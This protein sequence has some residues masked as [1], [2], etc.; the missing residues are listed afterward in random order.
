M[1]HNIIQP[2][3]TGPDVKLAQERLNQRGAT[4]ATDGIFGPLTENAVRAYQTAR[5]IPAPPAPP[6]PF[7]LNWP[8][9]VD[10]IVGN[11]TWGRLDPPLTVEGSPDHRHVR[12]L[13]DLLKKSGAPGA[14]PGPIDGIFGNHTKAAVKAFQQFVGIAQDGEVGPITWGKLHS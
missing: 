5:S 6:G 2:G 1:P 9:I 13:Q 14:N 12:L 10:G 4:L 7:A 3:S 11:E 8:L